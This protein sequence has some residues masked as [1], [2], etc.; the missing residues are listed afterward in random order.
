MPVRVIAAALAAVAAGLVVG[1]GTA[2]AGDPG[3]RL[4]A[5]A[6]GQQAPSWKPGM[7]AARDYAD[8]RLGEIAIAVVDP[9]GRLHT[10][11]AYSTAPMA[12]TF[13]VMLM[14]AYLRKAREREL[15]SYDRSLL[16]AMIRRSDNDAATRIRDMLGREP[17]E[18]LADDAR[19]R[20]F[21][22]HSIWG[23]C[24]TTA[25]DQ[26][27][28][29][30]RLRRYVPNRHWDFARK[31]LASI[32]ERQRWGVGRVGLH[33][34]KLYFKG[35]WGSGSGA[36][37]HQ[38]A[39]LERGDDRIGLAILTENNPSHAYGKETLEGVARR[40]LRNLPR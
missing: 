16:R 39:L 37:D 15:N 6:A 8:G 11:N 4:G 28:F 10:D 7:R 17:I 18:E 22:W 31:Q 1:A 2:P 26:A 12:S 14:V 34:W 33:G 29:L 25:R 3:T 32:V 38:V 9:R 24:R 27:F 36:V 5:A 20:G 19:M 40:L 23:S 21:Q 13:K 30:R 35:G